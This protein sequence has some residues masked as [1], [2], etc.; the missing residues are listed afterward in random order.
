MDS[1]KLHHHAAALLAVL[2]RS[3]DPMRLKDLAAAVFKKNGAHGPAMA[4][5]YLAPLLAAGSVIKAGWGLYV[6]TK[7][8]GGAL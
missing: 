5:N 1:P 7:K 8:E 4:S 2:Q 6:A 3:P